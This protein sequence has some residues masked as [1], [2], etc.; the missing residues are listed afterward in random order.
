LN[1]AQEDAGFHF[2]ETLTAALAYAVWRKTERA[3]LVSGLS[4]FPRPP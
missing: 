4:L 1:S 3:T 2:T